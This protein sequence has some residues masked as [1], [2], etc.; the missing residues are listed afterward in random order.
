MANNKKQH[1]V[2]KF[3][4]KNFSDENGRISVYN[5]HKDMVL[6]SV[7]YGSQCAKDYYYGEDCVWEKCL[8]LKEAQWSALFKRISN[9]DTL[10]LDDK[11]LIKSFALYQRQR[12]LAENEYK[13]QQRQELLEE[14]G[15]LLYKKNGWIFDE[16]A[17]KVVRERA[18]NDITPSESLQLASQMLSIVDDLS[19]TVIKYKTQNKLVSSDA[20]VVVINK[21]HEPTIGY[22]CMGIIF[23][24]P[25][26]PELLVV[27]YDS[28]MYPKYKNDSY[29]TSF[30]E[31]EVRNLNVLQFISAETILL[32]NNINDLPECTDE[33]KKIRDTNREGKV[34][35][36]LGAD[37]NKLIVTSQR[38]AIYKCELSFGHLNHSA[39]K[40]PFICR[41]AAP[42]I[43]DPEW[44]KKFDEKVLFS[45]VIR[46]VPELKKSVEIS[47]REWRKGCQLMATFAKNYWKH[48]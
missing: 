34:L 13:K 32:A 2:P 40:I 5:I 39:R 48:P 26:T 10:D 19:V 23:L 43:Y 28:K 42:R 37:D 17:E 30:D 29:I 4:L 11:N 46:D 3:Y 7:P 24:F 33:E 22:G 27:I 18:E 21:F 14:T 1:Y 16:E 41:E 15:R 12:T 8:S 9:G 38:K 44:E 45:S 20:P 6:A 36:T 25:I 47:S 35:S 31:T